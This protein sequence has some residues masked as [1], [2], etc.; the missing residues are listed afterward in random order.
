MSNN[1]QQQQQQKAARFNTGKIRPSLIPPGALIEVLKVLEM[2]AQKYSPWNWTKGLN[3]LSVCDS[4]DR[5]VLAFKGGEDKDPE[6]GLYH[7][8][9]IIANALFLLHFLQTNR[10]E[11]DD[12]SVYGKKGLD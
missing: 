4:L 12:R 5:H 11:L 6:S 10:T 7:A 3:Y 9:H 2:G 8:A 1:E